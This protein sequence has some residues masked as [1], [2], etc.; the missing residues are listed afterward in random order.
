MSSQNVI[1]VTI[2]NIAI[3]VGAYLCGFYFTK[4]FHEP[5]SYVGGLWAVISGII[6]IEGTARDTLHSAK[7]RIIGSLTGAII[8]GVYLFFF[9]FSLFGY[10]ICIAFG[11]LMCYILRVQHSIKLTGI[12]ISVVL[13]VSTIEKELHPI[14]NAGLRFVESAIGTGIA[15]SV[16][17][18]AYYLNKTIS[19]PS[20]YD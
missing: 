10:G 15:I 11:V 2:Q 5:T 3:I 1:S 17:F 13:I 6:V 12:T 20:Q 16:A 9:P 8:S 19:N 14:I 18:T 4:L 7:I